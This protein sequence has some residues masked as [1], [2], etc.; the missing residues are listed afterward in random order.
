MTVVLG[1]IGGTNTRLCINK[2]G[3]KR[4]LNLRVFKNRNYESFYQLL[5]EYL[6]TLP[7]E[8]FPEFGVFAVAGP[9]LEGK[10]RLTNLNWNISCGYLKRR[11]KLKKVVLVNDL[12]A[13]AASIV[14]TGKR[15]CDSVKSGKKKKRLPKAFIAPG[16]G[17]GES[18]LV[19]TNPLTILP[20][21]GG[22]IFFAPL[23]KEE[24]EYLEF[25]KTKGEELSWEK[26]ISGPAISFWYE[27]FWGQVIPPEKVTELAKNG[28]EKALRVIKKFF[29]LLGK[30]ASQLAF[31]SLPFGG[32]Y[33]AGGVSQA[34][35]DF[36]FDPSCKKEF[37]RGY[38]LNE[39]MRHL[40]ENFEINLYLNHP[41]P[42][43]LGA[44]VIAH[45]Q[46]F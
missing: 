4:L 12:F 29:E 8:L 43:L 23:S 15:Y 13:L 27:F 31:V 9:V 38:F 39:K 45:S 10:V 7:K 5:D 6:V 26:A 44:L 25:L 37:F 22:H 19:S 32:I 34:L 35:K 2:A 14:F 33:I 30:K 3:S 41:H 40:L 16:T 20:T 21:E 42:V 17:L 18:I 46:K 28:D 24:F 11:F 36:F 1:D